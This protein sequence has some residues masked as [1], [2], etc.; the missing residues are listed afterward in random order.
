MALIGIYL[1][2]HGHPRRFQLSW[3]FEAALDIR[4]L[5]IGVKVSR[6]SA[7]PRR[8]KIGSLSSRHPRVA[9]GGGFEQVFRIPG[10]LHP[11][12]PEKLGICLWALALRPG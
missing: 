5:P 6:R 11:D 10:S 4:K 8:G 12:G 9:A 2:F 3:A 7:F 1:I